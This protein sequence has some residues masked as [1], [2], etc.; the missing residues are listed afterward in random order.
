MNESPDT[1]ATL[2]AA[3]PVAAGGRTLASLLSV[4]LGIQLAALLLFLF[5][6]AGTVLDLHGFT[7][8]WEMHEVVEL[9]AIVSMAT[10][11][12]I[13]LRL[14][15]QSQRRTERVEE[16]LGLASASFHSVLLDRFDHWGLTAAEQEVAILIVKGCTIAEI[17]RELGKSEGT[18]K[19]QNSSIYQKSGL[20]GRVQFVSYFIELLTEPL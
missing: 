10:G 14:L 19:A 7:L 13:T 16:Q 12:A 3:T 8:S 6:F 5:D 1:D 2:P 4:A 11:S 17:A 18:I 9:L 20:S 15:W